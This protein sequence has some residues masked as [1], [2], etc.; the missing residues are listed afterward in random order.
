MIYSAQ[1]RA[2][3]GL[4]AWSQQDLAAAAGIG[5]A[6]VKRME[7]SPGLLMGH[8]GNIWRVKEALEARGVVFVEAGSG[9][10]PGVRLKTTPL[11]LPS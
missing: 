9:G 2:A 7:A 11:G 6:T 10:G 8:A 5:V 3:R 4:I 1:I